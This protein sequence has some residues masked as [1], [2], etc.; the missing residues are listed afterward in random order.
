M[1]IINQYGVNLAWS[2]R[3][4]KF[5]HRSEHAMLRKPPKKAQ[6][7]QGLVCMLNVKVY[8]QIQLEKD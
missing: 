3:L 6:T 4:I 1:A 2:R 7:L 8:L 5:T